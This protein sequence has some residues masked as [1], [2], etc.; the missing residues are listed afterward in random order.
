MNL[1]SRYVFREAWWSWLTVIAVLF[2][3]FMSNQFAQILG[4]AAADVLPK[5]TVFAV[6]RLQSLR[7]L[8]FLAPIA[9]FL[10]IMLALARF[11]RDAEM[12]ALL[13]CG[14]GPGRLL[15]P[16]AVLTAVL[17]A[18]VA[19]L[20]LVVMPDASRRIET[21]KYDAEADLD[22]G[23]LEPGRFSTP[24]SGDT[25][26][27]AER[28]EGEQ[29]FGVFWEREIDGRIVVIVAERGERLQEPGTGKLSFVLYNGTRYE[30]TPGALDFSIVKFREHGIPVRDDEREELVLGPEVTPTRTL[31]R[32]NDP[33]DRAE[34]Q[35]RISAPLSLF[36]LALLAVPLSRSTPREG[37]YAR[38]GVGLLLYIVYANLQSLARIWTERG[39][40]P[41]WLGVWWVHGTFVLFAILWFGRESGW[42]SRSRLITTEAVKAA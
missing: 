40:T 22:V 37:R 31:M 25:V 26:F 42:F 13:A 16:I 27:H 5:E 6:F 34:L 7:Y 41:P 17:A 21:I 3:I 8:T 15:Y 1:I 32:S 4:D 14:I 38:I 36:A 10:G 18:V 2:V 35:W 39:D 9:L 20:S 29:I 23:V 19:W 12:A 33:L 11:N 24:D 30:G 28:V